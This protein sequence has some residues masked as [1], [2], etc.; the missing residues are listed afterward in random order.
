MSQ[1]LSKAGQGRK[2]HMTAWQ[3]CMYLHDWVPCT[4]LGTAYFED[5]K[6]TELVHDNISIERAKQTD[7]I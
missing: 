2:D 3:G 4:F 5:L 7:L 6:V 1:L